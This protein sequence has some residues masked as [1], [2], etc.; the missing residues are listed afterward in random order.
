MNLIEKYKGKSLKDEF[1][2]ETF[3]DKIVDGMP[4]LEAVLNLIS[5]TL[6]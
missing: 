4:G 6:C 3:L 5:I 2:V 1:V